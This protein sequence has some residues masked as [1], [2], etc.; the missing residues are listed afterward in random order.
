VPHSLVNFSEE[1]TVAF[2]YVTDRSEILPAVCRQRGDHESALVVPAAEKRIHPLSRHVKNGRG[3]RF[4]SRR[5]V[6]FSRA[7]ITIQLQLASHL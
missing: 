1:L 3:S 4:E 6:D 5:P 7:V 2:L